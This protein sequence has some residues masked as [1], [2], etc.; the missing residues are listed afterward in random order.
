MLSGFDKEDK[1]DDFSG[2]AP[3]IFVPVLKLSI[4]SPTMLIEVQY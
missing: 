2:S 4:V 1:E 3:Y